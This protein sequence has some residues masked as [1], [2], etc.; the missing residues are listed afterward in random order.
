MLKIGSKDGVNH[1]A[2]V[3][4]ASARLR[5]VQLRRSPP[6][7]WLPRAGQAFAYLLQA[8]ACGC[9]KRGSVHPRT[10]ASGVSW[11]S[12]DPLLWAWLPRVVI[13]PLGLRH[14]H[15]I[16]RNRF[17]W[18]IQSVAECA[19]LLASLTSPAGDPPTARLSSLSG[20]TLAIAAS[21]GISSSSPLS[22][23]PL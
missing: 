1:P 20:W 15:G 16:S 7:G 5:D 19:G 21:R 8:K 23:S 3:A 18:A 11:C 12:R 2:P 4:A 22:R 13:R 6:L 14:R 17:R 10:S 9:V